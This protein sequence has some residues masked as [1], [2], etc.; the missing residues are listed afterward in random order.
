MSARDVRERA[1]FEAWQ[2]AWAPK[3]DECER[4]RIEWDKLDTPLARLTNG[5]VVSLEDEW[6]AWLARAALAS[7]VAAPVSPDEAT[8]TEYLSRCRPGTTREEAAR[9]LGMTLAPVSPPSPRGEAVVWAREAF[10]EAALHA[11]GCR[12]A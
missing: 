5:H 11:I 3:G 6:E 8:L 7:P 2:M 1:A 10:T 12:A 4:A 9:D